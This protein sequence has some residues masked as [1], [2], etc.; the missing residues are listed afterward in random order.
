MHGKIVTQFNLVI[1][2]CS[3]YISSKGTISLRPLPLP[4][5]SG[6]IPE[7]LVSS[8]MFGCHISTNI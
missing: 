1:L 3:Y 6:S 2:S 5:S 4:D 8:L 7:N